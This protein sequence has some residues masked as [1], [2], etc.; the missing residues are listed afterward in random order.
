M[1]NYR[2]NEMKSYKNISTFNPKKGWYRQ[3]Q[4]SWHHLHQ[5][6]DPLLEM[7]ERSV[8]CIIKFKLQLIGYELYGIEWCRW[9]LGIGE[10]F[11]WYVKFII[12]CSNNNDLIEY[13]SPT[14][15]MLINKKSN[16]TNRIFI[17]IKSR[18]WRRNSFDTKY[19]INRIELSC[20]SNTGLDRSWL[21]L[22]S[23]KVP[24]T[25]WSTNVFETTI[26]SLSII[27]LHYSYFKQIVKNARK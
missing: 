15:R 7:M 4:C 13:E 16:C 10:W 20:A 3:Y 17:F 14:W 12:Y 21:A 24:R 11:L 6:S 9:C 2:Y 27:S 25:L 5:L 23:Q 18:E 22:K 8:R 1:L 19:R 26:F